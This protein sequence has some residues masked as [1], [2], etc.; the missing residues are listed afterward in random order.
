[1]AHSTDLDIIC[2]IM[3]EGGYHVLQACPLASPEAGAV[4]VVD[5]VGINQVVCAATLLQKRNSVS[6]GV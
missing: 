3:E 5:V 6:R 1:M 2:L 4:T